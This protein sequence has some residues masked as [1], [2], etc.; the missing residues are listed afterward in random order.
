MEALVK[1]IRTLWITVDR[2]RDILRARVSV[3]A[4]VTKPTGACFEPITLTYDAVVS[5]LSV[6]HEGDK[7][8]AF[9]FAGITIFS[10][11]VNL[12]VP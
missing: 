7:I 9:L 12:F 10:Q 3:I 6:L 5:S 4:L 1:R 8:V 11:T 2:L